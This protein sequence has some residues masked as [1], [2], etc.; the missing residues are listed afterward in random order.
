MQLDSA[1]NWVGTEQYNLIGNNWQHPGNNADSVRRWTAPSAGSIRT[2]GTAS[3]GNVNCGSDGV[4]ITIRKGTTVLWQ[5]TVA[6]N[7]TT[8]VS[9]D[10]NTTV[11]TGDVISF[12]VN[13]GSENSCDKTML[14]PTIVHTKN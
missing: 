8:G 3:D 2:T 5:Q 1:S 13:K 7:N 14:D 4:V 9:F 11:V 10:L 12:A 6:R